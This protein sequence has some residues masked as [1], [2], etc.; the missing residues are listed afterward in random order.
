MNKNNNANVFLS[1]LNVFFFFFRVLVV[2]EFLCFP[3]CTCSLE[4]LQFILG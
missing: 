3:V 1:L 4:G 2:F